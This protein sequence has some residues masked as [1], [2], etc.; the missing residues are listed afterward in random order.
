MERIPFLPVR[1][2]TTPS[3]YPRV[4][5]QTLDGAAWK[6]T[7]TE[8]HDLLGIPCCQGE[9]RCRHIKNACIAMQACAKRQRLVLVTRTDEGGNLYMQARPQEVPC[10]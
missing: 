10:T 8:L 5:R 9:P 7:R 2:S 4:L 1:R 6:V 3:I